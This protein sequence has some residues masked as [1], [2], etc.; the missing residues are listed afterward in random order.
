IR[1]GMSPL[2][3]LRTAARP[4]FSPLSEEIKYLTKRSMGVGSFTETLLSLG[5]DIKS[6]LLD[7]TLALFATGI[8]SGGNLP[9]MLD[10]VATDVRE[11][12]RMQQQLLAGVNIY[13]IFIIFTIIVGMPALFAVSLKYLELTVTFPTPLAQSALSPVFMEQLVVFTI[14][15]TAIIASL[16]IGVAKTGKELS[17]LK[18]AVPITLLALTSFVL[19]RFFLLPFFLPL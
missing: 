5:K 18:Y 10:S 15:I 19:I 8:I 16:L 11:T 6:V 9:L 7:R 4:E 2:I 1:A 13:I 17:G 3:A 12:Q 14:T